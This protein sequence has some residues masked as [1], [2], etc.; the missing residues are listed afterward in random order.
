MSYS[1][2]T[3]PFRP[4]MFQVLNSRMWPVITILERTVLEI[5][6]NPKG[7]GLPDVH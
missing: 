4:G 6:I 5:F 1:Y 2:H 3:S 7:K